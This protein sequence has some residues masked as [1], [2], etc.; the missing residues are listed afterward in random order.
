MW[1]AAGILVACAFCSAAFSAPT[2]PASRRPPASLPVPAVVGTNRDG[3]EQESTNILVTAAG[4][5]PKKIL[6]TVVM[7]STIILVIVTVLYLC[8]RWD[9][10]G[11]SGHLTSCTIVV[12]AVVVSLL[13]VP[14][15]VCDRELTRLLASPEQTSGEDHDFDK[16]CQNHVDVHRAGAWQRN[17]AHGL[18][19]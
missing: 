4:E 7:K 2:T 1:N 3:F 14:R 5:D 15:V 12:G 8:D 18:L 6:L 17:R 9:L 13:S 11:P 19:N 16:G 10:F